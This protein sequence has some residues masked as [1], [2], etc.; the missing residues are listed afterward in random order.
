MCFKELKCL[1]QTTHQLTFFRENPG[2]RLFL[3]ESKESVVGIV[4]EVLCDQYTRQ[5]KQGIGI[6]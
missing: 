2:D 6:Y 5:R 4:V 1:N 3:N